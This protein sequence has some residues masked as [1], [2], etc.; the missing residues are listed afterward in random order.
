M[1]CASK[2]ST[3]SAQVDGQSCGQ[4]LKWM[5]GLPSMGGAAPC[6]LRPASIAKGRRA[7]DMAA[8]KE[9][10]GGLRFPE[11][12]VVLPDGGMLVCEIA[13]GRIT[14]IAPDRRAVGRCGDRRRPQRRRA[15]P[16]RQAL[17]LQQWR[18]GVVRPRRAGSSP[19]AAR[20]LMRAARSSASTWKPAR[21]RRSGATAGASRSRGRTTSSSTARAGSGSRTTARTAGGCAT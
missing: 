4:A 3:S 1:L 8:L 7:R 13:A 14:R 16:R 15:R 20:A 17:G 10:A 18:H 2:R 19:S 21:S 5:V 6:A 12:P 11:G 9:I